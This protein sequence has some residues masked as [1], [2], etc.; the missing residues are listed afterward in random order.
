MEH[1]VNKVGTITLERLAENVEG[2]DKEQFLWWLRMALLGTPIRRVVEKG[3]G[4]LRIGK[5][6]IVGLQ[7]PTKSQSFAENPV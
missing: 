3:T 7:Q 4:G 6:T 2:K 1:S 5:S